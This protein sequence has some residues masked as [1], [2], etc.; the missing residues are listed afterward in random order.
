MK[1]RQRKHLIWATCRRRACGVILV[2]SA[3]EEFF[4][5]GRRIAQL[6]DAGKPIPKQSIISFERQ[7]TLAGKIMQDD[8]V[9]LRVLSI[10][11]QSEIE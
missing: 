6:D 4:A 5:P 11:R 1:S 8:R 10:S 2:C 9:L 7:M 3:D